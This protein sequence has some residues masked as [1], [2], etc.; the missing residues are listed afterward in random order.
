MQVR[1]LLG[2]MKLPPCPWRTGRDEPEERGGAARGRDAETADEAA[3]AE[4]GARAVGVGL[5]PT[6]AREKLRASLR[7][8]GLR[9]QLSQRRTEN[10]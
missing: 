4:A 6:R 7:A 10:A 1:P 8:S 2:G 3:I 9:R 5:L